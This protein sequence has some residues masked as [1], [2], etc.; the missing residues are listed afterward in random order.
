MGLEIAESIR[1]IGGEGVTE[2]QKKLHISSLLSILQFNKYV[3]RAHYGEG[4]GL[5]N[6][7]NISMK[8]T[9]LYLPGAHMLLGEADGKYGKAQIINCDVANVGRTHSL[10]SGIPDEGASPVDSLFEKVT[11]KERCKSE[12]EHSHK[13]GAESIPAGMKTRYSL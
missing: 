2:S 9:A 6:E 3:L 10:T 1:L 7:R 5:S 8:N 13:T 12:K 11:F 4:P